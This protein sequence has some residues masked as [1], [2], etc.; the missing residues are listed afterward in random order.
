LQNSP[1]DTQLTGLQARE[2]IVASGGRTHR[3]SESQ[4]VRESESQRVRESESQ[5][6]RESESQRVRESEARSQKITDTR[7]DGLRAEHTLWRGRVRGGACKERAA[8]CVPALRS[9]GR[10]RAGE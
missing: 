9:W 7:N 5:R 8:L 2:N 1:D 4:R 3:E 6:V 10:G